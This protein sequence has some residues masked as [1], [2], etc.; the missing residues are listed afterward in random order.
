MEYLDIIEENFTKSDYVAYLRGSILM[1]LLEDKPFD[2]AQ[3]KLYADKLVEVLEKQPAD[4]SDVK[5]DVFHPVV[6]SVEETSTEPTVD[7]DEPKVMKEY[8]FKLGDH[9]IISKGKIDERTGIIVR[10]PIEGV[11]CRTSYVVDL[12]DKNLGW[13]ATVAFDGVDCKNAWVVNAKNMELL[14]TTLQANTWYH[15]TDFTLEELKELLPEGTRLQVE[16]QV[17]YNGI[18]TTPPTETLTTTVESVTTSFLT[19]EPLIETTGG[20][21]LKEWFMLAE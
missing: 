9:V 14:P 13:E 6:K 12:D 20:A 8:E 16:K 1:W 15:T 21:F 11:N 19:E 4:E 10:L 3:F 5:I 17:L 7:P 2:T 18:E